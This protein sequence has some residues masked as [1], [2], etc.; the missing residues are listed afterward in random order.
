MPR[1]PFWST[2]YAQAHEALRAV[3]KW[4]DDLLAGLRAGEAGDVISAE[5]ASTLLEL[6]GATPAATSSIPPRYRAGAFPTSAL[7]ARD[8]TD[9][10]RQVL[11]WRAGV[12]DFLS[13]VWDTLGEAAYGV[14]ECG[15]ATRWLLPADGVCALCL[16]TLP[17]DRAARAR[18]FDAC[19]VQLE[20][21][22]RA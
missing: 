16:G 4:R 13:D 17:A 21:S 2:D 6:L 1:D 20:W 9:G 15:R 22:K 3:S 8:S 10:L 14:E 7:A 5:L 18:H 11:L 12:C 19:A